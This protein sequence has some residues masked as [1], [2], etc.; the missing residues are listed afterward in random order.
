MKVEQQTFAKATASDGKVFEGENAIERC[1]QYEMKALEKELATLRFNALPKKKVFIPFIG[2]ENGIEEY[3]ILYLKDKKDFE[4]VK[5]Y[6]ENIPWGSTECLDEPLQY[7]FY[8]VLIHDDT[9]YQLYDM[10]FNMKEMEKTVEKMKLL[11]Q[12][13]KKASL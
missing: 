10:I 11:I 12:E 6:V 3:D 1:H 9:Y 2:F 7:P 4:T 5:N 8:G 13:H